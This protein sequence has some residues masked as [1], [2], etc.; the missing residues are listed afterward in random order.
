[1]DTNHVMMICGTIM[2]VGGF[3]LIGFAFVIGGVIGTMF[4]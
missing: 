1:M 4:S 2:L 3:T